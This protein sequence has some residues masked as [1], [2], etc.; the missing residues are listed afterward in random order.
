MLAGPFLP[1]I[2]EWQQVIIFIS[3]ISMAWGS[4]AAIGQN[5]IK[6]LMAY[7][8]IGHVGYAL[9]GLVPSATRSCARSAMLFYM[10]V[11]IFTNLGTFAVILAMRVKGRAVSRDIQRPRG[12]RSKNQSG[13]CLGHHRPHVLHGGYSAAWQA[14]WAKYFIFVAQP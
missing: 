10:L 14:S 6:R 1:L 11:Y 8:S 5:N 2:K 9:V 3:L 4:V 7:S 13:H 12:H